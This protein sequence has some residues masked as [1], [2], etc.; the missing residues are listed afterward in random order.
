MTF[1]IL[2][3]FIGMNILFFSIGVLPSLADDVDLIK[4][5]DQELW[6]PNTIICSDELSSAHSP[7]S[8]GSCPNGEHCFPTAVTLND[9]KQPQ[10]EDGDMTLFN[11][12]LCYS[13]INDG[14]DAVSASQNT[15]TGEWYRS[16]RLRRFPRLHDVNSFSADQSLGLMLWLIKDPTERRRVQF[17]WWIDWIGRNQRC[18]EDGCAKRVP[19]FCPDDDVDGR[20]DAKLGCTFK[21]S[22]IAVLG[23]VAN[24]FGITT[25]D[26]TLQ[27]A[28]DNSRKNALSWVV[29]NAQTNQPG[30]PQHLA[31]V[32][33]LILSSIGFPL[34]EDAARGGQL[35]PLGQ[36]AEN[37][38]QKNFGGQPLNPFFSWLAQHSIQEVAS[39]AT[40]ECPKTQAEVPPEGDHFQWSW[41]REDTEQAWKKTM[42]WDCR[43]IAG[44]VNQH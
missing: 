6:R 37:L 20:E 16:P 11:G 27:I 33:V 44:L 3:R 32:N 22:D 28:L 7:T 24:H 42:L 8:F 18:V 23:E 34:R 9:K 40:K 35:T 30:Y 39:L 29:Q 15:V 12:L 41:Q 13:G 1:G 38:T 26:T 4:K 36:A 43:F 19:R 31:A 17:K 21:P 10:C 2:L 5:L 14:C 25:S